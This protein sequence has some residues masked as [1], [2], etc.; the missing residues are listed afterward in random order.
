MIFNQDSHIFFPDEPADADVK[1]TP[2]EF[3]KINVHT[4]DGLDL[5]A[6]YAAGDKSK[7]AILWNHGNAFDVWKMAFILQ[8]YLEAGYCVYMTEYRGFAGNPGKFSE[9]GFIR[10]IAAGWDFLK[11][12]GYDKIIVHGYS[13]G[14]AHSARFA[15]ICSPYA[16]VLE[17]PF[18][19]F[20]SMVRE[21]IGNI[22]F[23]KCFLK[24][25][26]QT[27]KYIRK[28]TSPTLILCGDSDEIIPMSQGISVFDMC[29]AKNKKCV[30]IP[31]ATHRL[32]KSGSYD[33]ILKWLSALEH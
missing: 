33:I 9:D 18:A 4:S 16:L 31:G 20:A 23:I 12:N 7:P 30:V 1:P 19:S 22:P 8:P 6:L 3:E 21:R 13:M 25:K 17:A 24:Y 11:L 27:T 15:T 14:C 28:V 2:R 29:G 32:F 10:D 26:M 5:M